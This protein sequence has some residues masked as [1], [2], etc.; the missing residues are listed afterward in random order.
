MSTLDQVIELYKSTL[1]IDSKWY[2][3]DLHNFISN[4]EHKTE[5][6]LLQ[7]LANLKAL[8]GNDKRFNTMVEKEEKLMLKAGMYDVRNMKPENCLD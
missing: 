8:T 5:G 1:N 4:V 7:Q 6:E 2:G 3:S